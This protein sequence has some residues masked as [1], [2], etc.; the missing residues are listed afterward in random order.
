MYSFQGISYL[1][2]EGILDDDA[3]SVAAFIHYT[4]ALSW[5]SLQKFLKDR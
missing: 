4:N 2:R 1:V 3:N 5:K